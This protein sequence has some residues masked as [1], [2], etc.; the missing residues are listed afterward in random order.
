MSSRCP[1]TERNQVIPMALHKDIVEHETSSIDN[2][3]AKVGDAKLPSGEAGGVI[4]YLKMK[5][6]SIEAQ[7]TESLKD[8]EKMIAD[9]INI[10]AKRTEEKLMK[11]FEEVLAEKVAVASEEA[12]EL[13]KQAAQ[14]EC[15]RSLLEKQMVIDELEAQLRVAAENNRPNLDGVKVNGR[16]RK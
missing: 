5:L 1:V 10:G 14:V 12:V 9:A 16:K 3:S 15:E 11:S 2:A 8:R 4:D 13:G 7:L 6:L